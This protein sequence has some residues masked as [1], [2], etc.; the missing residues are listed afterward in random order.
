MHGARPP[1]CRE[2]PLAP[3]SAGVVPRVKR[4][5]EGGSWE[6]RGWELGGWE[7]G[8]WEEG[9]F[10][11]LQNGLFL[12]VSIVVKCTAGSASIESTCDARDLGWIPGLRKSLEKGKA[13]D[14]SIPAWRIPWT[15]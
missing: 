2:L 4:R 1:G 8:G 7:L 6:L 9:L 3:D 12:F 10:P 15:V 11:F 5:W 13:T 14:S